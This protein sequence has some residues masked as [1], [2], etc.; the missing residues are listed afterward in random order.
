[1]RVDTDAFRA[2]DFF[3]GAFFGADF[4]TGARFA[5]DFAPDDFAA[6][7]FAVVEERGDIVGEANGAPVSGRHAVRDEVR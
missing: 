1:M 4:L 7:F 3:A 2:A 6:A 5:P